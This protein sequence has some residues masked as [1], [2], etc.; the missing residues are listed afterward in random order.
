MWCACYVADASPRQSW[1]RRRNMRLTSEV[2][3]GAAQGSGVTYGTT[4]T[5]WSVSTS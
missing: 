5:N 4:D 1:A 3:I 2:W